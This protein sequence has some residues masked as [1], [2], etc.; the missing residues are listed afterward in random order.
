MNKYKIG[1][2]GVGS[3]LGQ[4][5]L[6]SIKQSKLEVTTVGFCV[7]KYSTGLYWCD[8]SYF[9]PFA[10]DPTFISKLIEVVSISEINILPSM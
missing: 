2:T 8:E 1:I 6:R 4:G 7:D 5:I 3:L 10:K 9:I